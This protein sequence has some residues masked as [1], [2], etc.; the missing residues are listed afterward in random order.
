MGQTQIEGL[1]KFIPRGG[2]KFD[3]YALGFQ[4]ST[5]KISEEQNNFI[6]NRKDYLNAS[7]RRH[8]LRNSMG[9]VDKYQ[10]HIF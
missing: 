9:Q 10:M 5:Y 7:N 1:D 4:E 6:E 2:N 8:S 3:L